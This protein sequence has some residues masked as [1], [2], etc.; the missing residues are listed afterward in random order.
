VHH[1]APWLIFAFVSCTFGDMSDK[2]GQEQGQGVFALCFLL[3][4]V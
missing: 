1:H 4:V 2:A 3:E